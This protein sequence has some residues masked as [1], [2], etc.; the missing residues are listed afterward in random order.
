VVKKNYFFLININ[1]RIYINFLFH[2]FFFYRF[3]DKNLKKENSKLITISF[4]NTILKLCEFFLIKHFF[5]LKNLRTNLYFFKIDLI[6]LK[7]VNF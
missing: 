2:Y 7:N 6:F 1:P 5:K 4:L 3:N